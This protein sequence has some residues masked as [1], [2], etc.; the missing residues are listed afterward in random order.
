[1]VGQG[2]LAYLNHI[3]DVEFESLSIESIL[4]VLQSRELIS[5]DLSG[6]PSDRNINLFID[7][8]SDTCLLGFSIFKKNDVSMRMR[9][10]F[11]QLNRVTIQN[12]YPLLK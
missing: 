2:C 7:L 3:R 8:E 4:L 11:Q 6:M 12:K 9:I 1:M 10:D 5:N